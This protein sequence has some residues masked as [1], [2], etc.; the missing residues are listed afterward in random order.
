MLLDLIQPKRKEREGETGREGGGSFMTW[1]A[2][3]QKCAA[4]AAVVVGAK[5][6]REPVNGQVDF[7]T[8]CLTY[9][10]CV[11]RKLVQKIGFACL[12][13]FPSLPPPPFFFPFFSSLL[14]LPLPLQFCLRA[15]LC[16][17]L[18]GLCGLFFLSFSSPPRLD[19]SVRTCAYV[20]PVQLGQ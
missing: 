8:R 9:G 11:R 17:R 12:L 13:D 16:G 15:L 1:R 6:E 10:L 7:S 19:F 2:Q 20:I 5:T 4:M 3:Q 14:L 18:C